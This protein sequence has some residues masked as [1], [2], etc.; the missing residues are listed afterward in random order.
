MSE[1][2]L[3]VSHSTSVP[4]VKHQRAAC[5]M[6][7]RVARTAL[8]DRSVLEC[9]FHRGH[10][11]HV[12][13]IDAGKVLINVFCALEDA[14]G[15]VGVSVEEI[16]QVGDRGDVPSVDIA[17]LTDSDKLVGAPVIHCS[18]KFGEGGEGVTLWCVVALS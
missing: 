4:V 9:P 10:A 3:K 1:C 18:L 5:R 16:V 8:V 17:P 12:P 7:K 11:R 14:P 6:A 2:L 13:V 15:L